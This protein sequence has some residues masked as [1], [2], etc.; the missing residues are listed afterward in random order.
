MGD[1]RRMQR[2]YLTF[3]VPATAVMAV[4][5]CQG[6]WWNAMISGLTLGLFFLPEGL[7]RW[8]RVRMSAVMKTTYLVFL[9]ASELLGEIG[10][11]YLRFRGWDVMLHVV[12][13]FLT[14]GLGCALTQGERRGLNGFCFAVT[15][16]TLWEGL[17]WTADLLFGLDMQ[18]D[19]LVHSIHTVLGHPGGIENITET[20]LVQDGGR[21]TALGFGGYLDIGLHDTMSD[22]LVTMAGALVLLALLRRWERTGKG[23][24][25]RQFIPEA[26]SPK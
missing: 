21:Q 14:A 12:S 26:Q 3:G 8:L 18:K 19:T 7:E 4:K 25:V 22:L 13:G 9:L 6:D 11:F 24:F 10:G 16:G 5:L 23:A 2:I 20:I 15:V 17:E 1:F